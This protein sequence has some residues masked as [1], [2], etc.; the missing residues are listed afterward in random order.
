MVNLDTY[1]EDFPQY[2]DVI[3]D[4]DGDLID[5]IKDDAPE[6]VRKSFEHYDQQIAEIARREA[7]TGANII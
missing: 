6:D 3:I 5:V 1:W 4:E 2:F 7:E